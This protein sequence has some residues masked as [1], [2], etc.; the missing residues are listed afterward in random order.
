MDE[1][2]LMFQ[3]ALNLLKV[4]ESNY[5]NEFFPDS[6]NRSYYAIFYA[7]RTLLLKKG[8]TPKTHAGTI[9]QFSFEFVRGDDF[10]KKIFKFFSK[11]E[12]DRKNADYDITFDSTK[13]KAKNDLNSAKLFVEECKKF[14]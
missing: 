7:A 5:S 13:E 12:E 4:A 2:S 11:L 9:K 10:D 3:R 1:I 6:I 14:L 8:I